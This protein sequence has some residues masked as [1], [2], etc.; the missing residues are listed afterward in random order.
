MTNT[1]SGMFLNAYQR[2][3]GIELNQRQVSKLYSIT[4]PTVEIFFA[5]FHLTFQGI[6]IK[7]DIH[8]ITQRSKPV[9]VTGKMTADAL[10]SDKHQPISSNH[11]DSTVTRLSHEIHYATCI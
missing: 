3:I 11:A 2:V 4:T 8:K 1:G 5:E 10:A 7:R 6:Y 9:Y